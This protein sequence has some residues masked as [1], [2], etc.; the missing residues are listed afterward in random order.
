M[1][2]VSTGALLGM[3]NNR[4]HKLLAELSDKIECDGFELMVY[5]SWYD[6]LNI[7]TK[8]VKSYN[9]KIPVLHCEKH[10][11]DSI[12]EGGEKNIFKALEL[13]EINCSTAA[14]LGAQK[15]VIHLWNGIASDKKIQNNLSVYP[16][17]KKLASIYNLDLLVEN[18][19]CN[20]ENPMKHF[21]ELFE[22]DS[23]IHFTLDTKMAAFHNQLELVYSDEYKW[24]WN[25]HIKHL[26]INDYKGGYMDW[27]NLKTLHIGDG[28]IDF[29]RFF[30]FLQQTKY[31]GDFTI[32]ATSF[33]RSTGKIDVDKLNSSLRILRE[34]VG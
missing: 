1:I 11:G 4:N 29:N 27:A 6:M 32:E 21:S 31:N 18:V 9:I 2:L 15:I 12:S 16:K 24:L 30:N 19:V 3:P 5:S 17:L 14:I 23:D 33:D 25:G 28:D 8:D 13:F 20:K 10:I 26:H 34:Y 7:I 22:K